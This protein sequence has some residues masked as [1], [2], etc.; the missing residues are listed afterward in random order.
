M[1]QY[2]NS[3]NEFLWTL[4]ANPAN[5]AHLY[6]YNLQRLVND[7]P[8]SG[9]LQALL[10]HASEEKNLKRASTYFNPKS[11]FKLINAPST[12]TGVPDERIFI[13]S[14]ISINGGFQQSEPHFS[15]RN[16]E[17]PIYNGMESEIHE[18]PANHAAVLVDTELPPPGHFSAPEHAAG[19]EEITHPGEPI[20]EKNNVAEP[21]IESVE[22]VAAEE[23]EPQLIP[24]AVANETEA[25]LP[26]QHIEDAF[27]ENKDELIESV[28]PESEIPHL[29]Q[30]IG[31]ENHEEVIQLEIA[32]NET[33]SAPQIF[34]EIHLAQEE[35]ITIIAPE[36]SAP[37]PVAEINEELATENVET[38]AIIEEAASIENV[39]PVAEIEAAEN[40]EPIAIIDET[41]GFEP[42]AFPA[43]EHHTEQAAKDTEKPVNEDIDETYDEIVGIENIHFSDRSTYKPATGDSFFSFDREFGAHADPEEEEAEQ[44]SPAA[45][46]NGQADA[47]QTDVSK[48]NDEKLPYSFLW[49]LDKT[50]KEHS[51][52]YQPYVKP[53]A[54]NTQPGKRP[55]KLTD[56]LQQQYFEN[57]FHITTVDDLDKSA[58]PPKA[59][60][61]IKR[62]EHVIIERFIKEEPQIRPQ[63]SDKLD[64]EN[65]AKKSSEDRDELVTETLAAIYTDQMLYHKAIASYK[66]LMLKFPEKSRYFADKIEQLEKKTN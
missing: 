47:E 34:E 41:E 48:Y 2:S 66:K 14:G 39:E 15:D 53:P 65:K 9:I 23:R 4:L 16:V 13:Q 8:Q 7:F 3:Q 49:W 11:L 18:E 12:F 55:K 45:A 60:Y 42:G 19:H 1:E 30:Q 25:P 37:E 54:A 46:A 40:I 57:I 56:E 64:N 62:K 22:H 33:N 59:P 35:P 6:A 36:V 21:G 44:A 27:A 61:D 51:A 26:T 31:D 38:I 29:T 17:L 5:D 24:E 43:E 32:V 63:S 10:A 58:A 52:V 50:R 20:A 28:I